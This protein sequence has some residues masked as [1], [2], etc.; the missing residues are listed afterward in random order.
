MDLTNSIYDALV[1]IK[2]GKKLK[3]STKEYL[4][5]QRER[6][7]R[8]IPYEMH[9]A[10]ADAKETGNRY[11]L[12]HGQTLWGGVKENC[13][14]IGTLAMACMILLLVTGVGTF[15]FLSMPA[16]YVSIDVNPSVELT[17]NRRNRVI[18][19]EAYNEDG[20]MV[21]QDVSVKGSMY[22]D[23][24]DAI[25]ESDAMQPYLTKDALLTFTVAAENPSKVQIIQN[26][27][28]QNSSYVSH[29]GKSVITDKKV[30]DEAHENNLSFGKY[31]AYLELKKYDSEITVEQCHHM[32]MS[33]ISEQI[34]QH[35]TACD[36]NN[37]GHHANHH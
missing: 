30:V 12:P 7:E 37:P 26:E 24:I 20:E 32:S 9:S 34:H 36:D 27:I 33:E 11:R 17:L 29:G 35:E 19:A 1:D 4:Q 6:Y 16:Y 3:S 15:S 10:K 31:N 8:E 23:A 2:A 25:M 22:T 13:Q 5:Q 21:L 28:T 14:W 18:S